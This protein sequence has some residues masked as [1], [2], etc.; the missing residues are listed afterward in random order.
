MGVGWGLGVSA[1]REARKGLCGPS[2]Y[3]LRSDHRGFSGRWEAPGSPKKALPPYKPDHSPTLW[4]E[5]LL[6]GAHSLG[7]GFAPF[8]PEMLI[9]C[10]P[11]RQM[12]SRSVPP[13]SPAAP[14]P[15]NHPLFLY[16]S[17]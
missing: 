14:D 6:Q 17:T 8:S 3:L 13:N 15:S 7:L 5:K 16:F 12:D 10:S 1:S 11:Q 4:Q 9:S 2:T